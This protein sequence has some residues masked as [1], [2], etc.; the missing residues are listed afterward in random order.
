M[1]TLKGFIFDRDGIVNKLINETGKLRPPRKISELAINNE[2]ILFS[3]YLREKGYKLF[4]ISNQP[5]VKRGVLS[6]NDLNKINQKISETIYF[7]DIICEVDDDEAKKKPSPYMVKQVINE[8]NLDISNTW[9]FGDRWVDIL[10]AKKAG[11]RSVLLEKDY[12]FSETSAGK[13]PEN[14]KPTISISNLKGL[15]SKDFLEKFH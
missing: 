6:I 1:G 3:K 13:P 10:S 11:I 15:K 7:D 14:L 9:L 8:N 4:I 2:I 12:S 5:D